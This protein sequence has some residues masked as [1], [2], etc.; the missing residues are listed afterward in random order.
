MGVTNGPRVLINDK[1]TADSEDR[2]LAI[3]LVTD[4]GF[5][6]TCWEDYGL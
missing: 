3:N 2:A 4:S 1:L 5:K 6:K